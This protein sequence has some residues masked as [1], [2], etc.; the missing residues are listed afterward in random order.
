MIKLI[1][2]TLPD[3]GGRFTLDNFLLIDPPFQENCTWE[4]ETDSN[5]VIAF[6]LIGISFRQ[7][8]QFFIVRG[9]PRITR[10]YPISV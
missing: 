9:N 7:A 5:R 3:C 8:A 2:Q 4:I 1:K 6:S 10:H